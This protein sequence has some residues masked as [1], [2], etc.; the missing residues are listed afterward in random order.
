MQWPITYGLP[1]RKYFTE[2]A[3]PWLYTA[4][5]ERVAD[6][7]ASVS[8]F[9]TTVDLWSSR[10]L[11][12]YLRLSVHY[13]NEDWKL[14]NVCLQMSYVPDDHTGEVIA[15]GLKDSLA[16]WKMSEDWQVCMTTDS[17]SNIIKALCL[18]NW[19]GLQCLGTGFIHLASG[20]CD[21]G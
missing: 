2:E 18:N 12:P 8:Y 21:I 17:W 14:K 3:L 4:T 6:K 15:P 1:S 16:S 11:K 9:S 19:T 13:I 20:K 5:R 7:L 10:T